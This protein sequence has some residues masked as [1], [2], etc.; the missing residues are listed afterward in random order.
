MPWG[1]PKGIL[2]VCWISQPC[3]GASGTCTWGI[4]WPSSVPLTCQF[5]NP[6]LPA[7]LCGEALGQPRARPWPTAMSHSKRL[8]FQLCCNPQRH[9]H[10]FSQGCDSPRLTND[11]PGALAAASSAHPQRAVPGGFPTASGL[12]CSP[13]RYQPQFP[14]HRPP[15][16]VQKDFAV[17]VMRCPATR[18][19]RASRDQP[20]NPPAAPWTRLPPEGKAKVRC[21]TQLLHCA[22]L[23]LEEIA[24]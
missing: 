16:H 2:W 12:L 18:A 8:K 5:T 10:R 7:W 11:A 17:L 19:V 23:R 24:S 22:A 21:I 6:Q 9:S 15:G 13:Q 4:E 3:G 14:K 20:P 1:I